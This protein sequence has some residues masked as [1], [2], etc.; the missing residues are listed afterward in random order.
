VVISEQATLIN[1][2]D[3]PVAIEQHFVIRRS[4][5]G[6]Q[7]TKV[8]EVVLNAPAPAGISPRLSNLLYKGSIPALESP[9]RPRVPL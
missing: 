2:R 7:A 4:R 3:T 9:H 5:R 6:R 1:N 8:Q